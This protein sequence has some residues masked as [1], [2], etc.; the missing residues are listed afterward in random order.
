MFDDMLNDEIHVIKADGTRQG[1]FK[2]TIGKGKATVFDTSIDVSAGDQVER[3]LPGGKIEMYEV[4]D[5]DYSPGLGGFNGIPPN[6]KL[7]LEKQGLKPR[8]EPRAMTV[9]INGSSGFQV[10]DYN[11]MNVGTAL[12]EL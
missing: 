5:V 4:R 9:H 7:H 2:T 10:G 3:S 12:A 8:M 11:Q 1:P 6:Y